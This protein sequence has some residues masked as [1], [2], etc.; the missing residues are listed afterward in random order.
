M[1][2]KPASTIIDGF[3]VAV[4]SDMGFMDDA[5]DMGTGVA[6]R[7]AWTQGELERFTR[8]ARL[9]VAAAR[10]GV[11][12]GKAVAAPVAAARAAAPAAE[13]QAAAPVAAAQAAAPAAEAQATAPVA[14]AQAAAPA[15][16]AAT[17]SPA[18]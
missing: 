17:A 4:T 18:E 15:A 7:R 14:A 9:G 10:I 3:P 11:P 1:G 5:S 13:A 2:L 6:E 16:E 12:Y 8:R